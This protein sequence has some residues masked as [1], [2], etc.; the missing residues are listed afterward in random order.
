MKKRARYETVLSGRTGRGS[1]SVLAGLTICIYTRLYGRSSDS[2][3][4]IEALDVLL[5]HPQL[6]DLLVTNMRLN[7]LEYVLGS[8]WLGAVHARFFTK[9]R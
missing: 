1:L 2:R 6:A 5:C 4:N 8:V 3:L 9:K 7:T